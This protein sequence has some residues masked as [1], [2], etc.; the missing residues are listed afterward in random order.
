MVLDRLYDSA[1]QYFGSSGRSVCSREIFTH[2]EEY[3]HTGQRREHE[4]FLYRK[5]DIKYR[6]AKIY[7]IIILYKISL[8][9][10]GKPITT[11]FNINKSAL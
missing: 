8:L 6:S 9:L 1:Y 2:A 10:S 7:N 5:L 11:G 4:S 3:T